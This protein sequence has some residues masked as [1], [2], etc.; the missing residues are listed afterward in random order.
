MVVAHSPLLPHPTLRLYSTAFDFAN[1]RFLRERGDTPAVRWT[2][3][4]QS[5]MD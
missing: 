4:A 5:I 1:F 3:T 2:E